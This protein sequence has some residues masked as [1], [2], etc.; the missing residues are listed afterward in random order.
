MKTDKKLGIWM[1]NS[2]A[3]IIEL[4]TAD[5]ETSIV[6]SAFTNEEREQTLGKSEHVMHNKEQQQQSVY[7]KKLSDIIAGYDDVLLFGPTNAK[8]ELY[9]TLKTDQHFKDIKIE[10]QSADKMT[11]HQQQAFVK[12]YFK[13]R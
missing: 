3:H 4:T 5:V 11:E 8:A 2:T 7:Y 9:N 12:N 1:D 13:V 10:V 6:A